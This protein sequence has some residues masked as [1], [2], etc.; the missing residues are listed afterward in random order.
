MIAPLPKRRREPAR[1]LLPGPRFAL[2]FEDGRG[3][4]V[5]AKPLR[6]AFGTVEALELSLGALRFPLDL[7]AGAARFRTH[8][9]V[10]RRARAR[11]DVSAWIAAREPYRLVPLSAREG[12]WTF[13]LTDPFGTVAFDAHV[14][15]EGADL[16]IAIAS[17]R[18]VGEGPAPP[19]ARVLA[20]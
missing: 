1:P 20:A 11:L 15:I 10:L 9:T 2:R 4:L 13:A 16:W 5:L 17:A 12:A 18:S 6:F 8:R 7:S 14:R 19:L 3:L